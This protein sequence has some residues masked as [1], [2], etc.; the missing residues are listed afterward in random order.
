MREITFEALKDK[1]RD[2][3]LDCAYY[4]DEKLI[5]TVKKAS[6][7]ESSAPGRD[8]LNDLLLNYEIAAR[9]RV[10]ICQDTGMA[11]LFI[12]WGQECHLTGGA[13]EDAVNQGVREAYID[14]YLRKSIVNDPLYDRKNTGDNTPAVIHTRIVPGDQVHILAIA[15]G[16]GSE[17]MSRI[18]MLPPSAGEKGVLDFIVD[19]ARQAGPNPCPPIVLGICVGGSF[20]TCA[21]MAKKMTAEPVDAVNPDPRYAALEKKAFEAV[22]RLNI[23][24]AGIGGDTTALSLHIAALPTHIAG[25][26]VAVSVCCHAC[27]HKEGTL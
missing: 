18:A 26:P 22:N 7:T 15:K 20:E 8:V 12:E 23:G 5:D 2:L 21:E 11:M 6:E 10:A 1:V 16:F 4:L 3:Y 17:N 19:T 14:G 27:R 13:Y 25:M 9:D 24:P